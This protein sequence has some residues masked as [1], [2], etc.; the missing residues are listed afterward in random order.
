MVEPPPV[1]NGDLVVFWPVLGR[2][3][4]EKIRAWVNNRKS[5]F[6]G[7]R[8]SEIEKI[9]TTLSG[10]VVR[11]F[12]YILHFGRPDPPGREIAKYRFSRPFW[13]RAA[14]GT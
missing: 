13:P 2:G 7:A 6:S 9:V 10:M 1:E 4:L 5:Q 8:G 14:L 3:H 12:F 11:N